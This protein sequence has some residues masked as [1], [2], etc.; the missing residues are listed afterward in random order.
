MIIAKRTVSVFESAP[1]SSK[2]AIMVQGLGLH[3]IMENEVNIAV[4]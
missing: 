3:R 4:I 1:T 2:G